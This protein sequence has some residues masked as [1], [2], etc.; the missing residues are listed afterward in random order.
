MDLL[1]IVRDIPD[2]PKPGIH[3]KDITTL[4]KDPIAF[5]YTIDRFVEYA[6][7]QQPDVIVAVESRGF[8][9]AAP[10]AERLGA[11]FVPVR[12]PGKLPA[13]T[14]K[15]EYELEYGTGV[16]EIH[17]DAIEKGQR[18]LIVDDVLATGGTIEATRKLV[19]QFGGVVVGFAFLMELTFLGGRNKLAGYDVFSLIEC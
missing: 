18:V 14:T 9:F 10:I 4:L 15:I 1:S 13:V 5:R 16:L 2:F 12:K 6:K 19:E 17:T 3:F 11:G 7:A 8:I